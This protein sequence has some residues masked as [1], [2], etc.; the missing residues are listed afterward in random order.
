MPIIT[1]VNVQKVD[2]RH[3]MAHEPLLR[4]TVLVTASHNIDSILDEMRPSWE[5]NTVI[6]GFSLL[7]FLSLCRDIW[8]I[9]WNCD[10]LSFG[11]H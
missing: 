8:T 9:F 7:I 6:M 2:V 11:S 4:V 10:T 1:R 3:A 5:E